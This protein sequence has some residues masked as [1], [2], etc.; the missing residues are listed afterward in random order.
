VA[1][2]VIGILLGSYF[3]SKVLQKTE[4]KTVRLI[5]LVMLCL[6]GIEMILKGFGVS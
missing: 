4:G 1:P 2:V 3:G 5:F 6:I